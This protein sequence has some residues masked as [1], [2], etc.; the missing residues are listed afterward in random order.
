MNLSKTPPGR[1]LFRRRSTPRKSHAS[2]PIHDGLSDL[3]IGMLY[4]QFILLYQNKLAND[5]VKQRPGSRCVP[6]DVMG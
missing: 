1:A 5:L 3:A 4:H 6:G 2:V